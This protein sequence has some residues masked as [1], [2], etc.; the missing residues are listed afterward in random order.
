M[1]HPWHEIEK[2]EATNA[3]ITDNRTIAGFILEIENRRF[4]MVKNSHRTA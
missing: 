1:D 3:D 2:I 4:A